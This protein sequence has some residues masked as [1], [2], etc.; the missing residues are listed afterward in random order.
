MTKKQ[1]SQ[2]KANWH[3]MPEWCRQWTLDLI[4]DSLDNNN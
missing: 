1:I 2:I 4:R 3:Q